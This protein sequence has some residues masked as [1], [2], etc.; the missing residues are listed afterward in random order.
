MESICLHFN[1]PFLL[2]PFFQQD[3][4]SVC[5]NGKCAQTMNHQCQALW[6]ADAKAAPD[7]CWNLLNRNANSGF[8][9]CSPTAN[10]ACTSLEHAKCG[11]IQCLSPDSKPFMVNYGTAYKKIQSNGQKCR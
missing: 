6:N 5:Y 4:N 7:T 1:F 3:D 9:T 8:G 2:F 11:Q 10:V